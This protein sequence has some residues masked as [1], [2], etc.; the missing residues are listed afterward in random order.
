MRS[1]Q[2]SLSLY[3]SVSRFHSASTRYQHVL[4]TEQDE[5]AMALPSS[6][7][8]ANLQNASSTSR[9]DARWRVAAN[10]MVHCCRFPLSATEED[11]KDDPLSSLTIPS[12]QKPLKWMSST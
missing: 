6:R 2:L 4:S 9:H 10:T 3:I 11:D 5:K 1:I 12:V 7:A 8:V